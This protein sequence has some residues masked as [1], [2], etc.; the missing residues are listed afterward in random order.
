MSL[1]DA[2]NSLHNKIYVNPAYKVKVCDID[3]IWLVEERVFYCISVM[4][5]SEKKDVIN[6]FGEHNIGISFEN[7]GRMNLMR[8]NNMDDFPYVILNFGQ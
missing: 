8:L 4:I 1:E 2:M 7:S 5:D 6:T 3:M